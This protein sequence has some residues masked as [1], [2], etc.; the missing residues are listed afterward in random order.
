[1]RYDAMSIL[2][3]FKFRPINL[4]FSGILHLNPMGECT[5]V[6]FQ[7]TLV[8]SSKLKPPWAFPTISKPYVEPCLQYVSLYITDQNHQY[9]SLKCSYYAKKKKK[10]PELDGNQWMSS[11]LK[12]NMSLHKDFR[13][14]FRVKH[15][16]SPG[17][18]PEGG[19]DLEPR[20]P[21]VTKGPPKKKKKRKGKETRGCK[22]NSL[23]HS[24]TLFQ[25][26]KINDSLS[27]PL[28]CDLLDMPLITCSLVPD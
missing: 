1:M 7:F 11:Y 24:S 8:N 9:T 6:G 15:N 23:R 25:G 21:G 3:G 20:P 18:Y 28:V 26:A 19:G 13:G 12:N 22:G 17:A 5:F 10:I 2:S 4:K 16:A 14:Y 27:P